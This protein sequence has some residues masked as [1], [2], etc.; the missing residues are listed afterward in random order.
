MV[1]SRKSVS[2]TT[3]ILIHTVES[4]GEV[5]P[6]AACAKHDPN[7][8]NPISRYDVTNLLLEPPN[9]IKSLSCPYHVQAQ[10]TAYGF[11]RLL[12]EQ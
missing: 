8:D 10:L 9:I 4:S 5:E 7:P 11:D 3:V 1:A 12:L 6:G 2:S